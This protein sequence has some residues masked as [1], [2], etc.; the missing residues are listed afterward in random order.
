MSEENEEK[1]PHCERVDLLHK[2]LVECG[3]DVDREEVQ[4]VDYLLHMMNFPY[5]TKIL[6]D[7][8]FI[9]TD[10]ESGV[11]KEDVI[12]G[13]Y[14]KQLEIPPEEDENKKD[15]DETT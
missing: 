15:A 3:Y 8:E 1:C 6:A 5:L 7:S 13:H 9:L 10:L 14:E 4:M 2:K 11:N 12:L